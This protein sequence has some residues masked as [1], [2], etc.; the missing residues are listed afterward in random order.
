MSEIIAAK[1]FTINDRVITE[2][3]VH[4]YATVR[5][6]V[7]LEPTPDP[8]EAL[9]KALAAVDLDSAVREGEYAEEI[10]GVLVDQISGNYDHGAGQFEYEA[11]IGLTPDGYRDQGRMEQGRFIVVSTGNIT[12]QDSEVL[13]QA[14]AKAAPVMI[15]ESGYGWIVSL[16]PSFQTDVPAVLAS[17]KAAGLSEAFCTLW[18]G[19]RLRGYGLM[20]LDA[21]AAAHPEFAT[22]EW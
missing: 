16:M 13:A 18:H 7:P 6:R 4:L 8:A 17:L 10:T 15:A 2:T 9:K 14:D 5:V 1:P 21:D 20:Q 3:A 22:F 12:K 19:L 11:E